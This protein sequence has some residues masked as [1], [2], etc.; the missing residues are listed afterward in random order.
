[1]RSSCI[2]MAGYFVKMEVV[3]GGGCAGSHI[4]VGMLKKFARAPDKK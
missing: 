3:I 1:M 2:E 4:S